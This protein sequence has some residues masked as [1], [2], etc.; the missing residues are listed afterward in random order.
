MNRKNF[1][2]YCL[3]IFIASTFAIY[4]TKKKSSGELSMTAKLESKNFKLTCLG[5]PSKCGASEIAV[6]NIGKKDYSHL[7][8]ICTDKSAPN[9]SEKDPYHTMPFSLKPGE[10]KCMDAG[11]H[12]FK[13]E[14]KD[15]KLGKLY[16]LIQLTWL[17]NPK[18]MIGQNCDEEDKK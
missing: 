2:F 9:A 4:C 18:W 12:C 14:H 3:S 5:E 1:V 17:N 8:L 10:T 6:T 13:K 7:I 16:T 11:T 15:K